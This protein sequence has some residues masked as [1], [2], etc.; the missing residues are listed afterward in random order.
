MLGDPVPKACWA[1]GTLQHHP[2]LAAANDVDNAV[3]V[4]EYWGGQVGYYH[5]SRTQSHGHDVSTEISGTEG[6][7]S[8][9]LIPRA[10]N[11]VV[12]DKRG[13]S[14][15]V[16]EEYWQRF[17]YAFETEAREFIDSILNNT[18]VPVPLKMG[19]KVMEIARGLQAALW[20]GEVTRWNE[21]GQIISAGEKPS[22]G[23]NGHAK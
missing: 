21:K 18:P 11:V 10:N 2:E 14:H 13:M 7:I 3:G 5:C 4:V 22:T 23:M 20:S 1:T 8:V 6:R 16:Q 19:Q 17:E 12:G 15:E 9:N